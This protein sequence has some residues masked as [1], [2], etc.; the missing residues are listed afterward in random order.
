MTFYCKVSDI[1]PS[2]RPSACGGLSG[3]PI[4]VARKA[5]WEPAAGR[6]PAPQVFSRMRAPQLK[7]NSIASSGTFA[8]T[9]RVVSIANDPSAANIVCF[10]E[11]GLLA[12]LNI[13]SPLPMKLLLLLRKSG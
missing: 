11:A 1:G 8:K 9:R 10:V 4:P 6:G 7:M 3:R 12:R 2:A 13:Y 5:G